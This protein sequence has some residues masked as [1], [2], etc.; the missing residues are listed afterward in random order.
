MNQPP[1]TDERDE[2]VKRYYGKMPNK[3]LAKMIGKSVWAVEGRAGKFGLKKTVE[4]KRSSG[5][6][7]KIPD[8]IKDMILGVPDIDRSVAGELAH[9][10][11]GTRGSAKARTLYLLWLMSQLRR[12]SG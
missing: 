4:K 1:W 11:Q 10:A 5:I 8:H 2:L 9:S 7:R 3:K 6:K 12:M